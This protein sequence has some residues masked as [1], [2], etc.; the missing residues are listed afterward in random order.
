MVIFTRRYCTG[1]DLGTAAREEKSKRL[2]AA[3]DA[4]VAAGIYGSRS[5]PA[6][7]A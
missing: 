5:N 7:D 3:M 6:Y 2:H 4:Y 1:C